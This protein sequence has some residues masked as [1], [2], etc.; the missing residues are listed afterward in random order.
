MRIFTDQLAIFQDF[1]GLFSTVSRFFRILWWNCQDFQNSPVKFRDF[2]GLLCQ[3]NFKIYQDSLAGGGVG[4]SS[5]FFR[6]PFGPLKKTILLWFN[7]SR[8]ATDPSTSTPFSVY[9][10]VR[11]DTLFFP[12]G[13]H[14]CSSPIWFFFLILI[15]YSL[16]KILLFLLLRRYLALPHFQFRRVHF[17]SE[18]AP[19]GLGS[20]NSST[21]LRDLFPFPGRPFSTTDL[22]GPLQLLRNDCVHDHL[23]RV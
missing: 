14:R 6:I 17:R 11:I 1:S 21:F 2:S 5:G 8:N 19:V 18:K 13:F 4:E 10:S 3:W 23:W 20:G 16:K 7:R 22:I 9:G 15:F 12:F